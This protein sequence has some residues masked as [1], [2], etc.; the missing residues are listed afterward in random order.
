MEE[1]G[2]LWAPISSGSIMED[3][4]RASIITPSVEPDGPN[5]SSDGPLDSEAFIKPRQVFNSQHQHDLFVAFFYPKPD[6]ASAGTVATGES[7]NKRD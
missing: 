1:K 5:I 2:E 3:Q 6:I 7:S 4:I